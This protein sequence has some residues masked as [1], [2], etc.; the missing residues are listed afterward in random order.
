MVVY[1][2]F[3]LQFNGLIPV[4]DISGKHEGFYV[5]YMYISP[6]CTNVQPF[7]LER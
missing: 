7:T 2:K 3:Y 5:D 6:L 4:N 1:T